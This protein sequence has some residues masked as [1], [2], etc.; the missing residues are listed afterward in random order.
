[1]RAV[2]WVANGG[3]LEGDVPGMRDVGAGVGPGGGVE[4]KE[5]AMMKTD[6]NELKGKRI[7]VSRRYAGTWRALEEVQVTE[8]SPS[9]KRVKLNACW[10][11]ADE[12]VVE[13]VLP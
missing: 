6:W 12:Y 1:M 2:Q 13:E 4:K 5:R 7:L 9:G 8:V 10:A 3:A 11:E